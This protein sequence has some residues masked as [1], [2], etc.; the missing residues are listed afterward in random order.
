[1]LWSSK[2]SMSYCPEILRVSIKPTGKQLTGRGLHSSTFQL[3][4]S[5]V[6]HIQNTLHTPN[7][8]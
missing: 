4:L 2:R 6:Q 3:N 7:T 1:V 5:C 8:P